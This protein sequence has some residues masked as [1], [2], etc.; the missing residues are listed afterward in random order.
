MVL[1]QGDFAKLLR[2][3]VKTLLKIVSTAPEVALNSLHGRG[4]G[5]CF[6]PDR[7]LALS[8]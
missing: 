1:S 5:H 7:P 6:Q 3:S 4:A 8:A 2:V